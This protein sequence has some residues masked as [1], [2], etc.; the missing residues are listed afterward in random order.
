M[1]DI[2][3]PS[4]AS[5]LSTRL[6]SL[7][8]LAAEYSLEFP[9]SAIRAAP[10]PVLPVHLFNVK[11]SFEINQST[12]SQP[13]PAAFSYVHFHFQHH[14]FNIYLIHS[15]IMCAARPDVGESLIPGEMTR[16]WHVD[17]NQQI[18]NLMSAC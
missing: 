10:A 13:E 12:I 4:L 15:L 1:F 8:S 6:I 18:R 7:S 2:T 5:R 17:V 14:H 11:I 3:S 9:W 16:H